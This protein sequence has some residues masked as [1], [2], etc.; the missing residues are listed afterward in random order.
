[1]IELLKYSLKI[2]LTALLGAPLVFVTVRY[3]NTL[4]EPETLYDTINTY[5]II[6]EFS[7]LGSF[8]TWVAFLIGVYNVL[9]QDWPLLTNKRMI[10]GL[11]VILVFTTFVVYAAILADLSIIFD[12]FFIILIT[13]Y[14]V[15]LLLSAQFYKLPQLYSDHQ[16]NSTT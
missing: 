3:C 13:P 5:F 15:S 11:T 4:N 8:L 14:M 1:M 16:E 2:W 7:F 12:W 6:V 10:Q 9:K